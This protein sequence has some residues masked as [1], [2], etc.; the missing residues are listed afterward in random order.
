MWVEKLVS[1]KPELKSSSPFIGER[2]AENVSKGL[3]GKYKAR[4]TEGVRV[5]AETSP[6]QLLDVITS[7]R[8]DRL[9]EAHGDTPIQDHDIPALEASRRA[10]I[11]GLWTNRIVKINRQ[12][13]VDL[14]NQAVYGNEHYM[15]PGGLTQLNKTAR[16]ENKAFDVESG[17][18]P[19]REDFELAYRQV[20]PN[21]G[22]ILINKILDQIEANHHD[23]Y[24]SLQ[25]GWRQTIKGKLKEWM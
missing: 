21:G 18:I 22:K 20:A 7:L 2:L 1:A 15:P 9:V 13:K 6:E 19:T 12:G 5:A 23:I 8:Q 17:Y 4:L 14:I 3:N 11:L 16:P 10:L 25:A 24:P